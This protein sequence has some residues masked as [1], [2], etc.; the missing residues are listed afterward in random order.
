MILG[1]N[2]A[3]K[4]DIYW[5]RSSRIGSKWIDEKGWSLIRLYPLILEDID[6][7]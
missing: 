2:Y 6:P 4:G 7:S 1:F 3:H 5:N